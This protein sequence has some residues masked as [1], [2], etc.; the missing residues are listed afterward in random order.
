MRIIE[1]N[2]ELSTKELYG[3]TMSP[4]IGKMKEC[5]GQVLEIENWAKYADEDKNGVEKEI[6]S[7]QTKDG[8]VVATNSPTFIADFTRMTSLF[9]QTGETLDSIE[10]IEGKSK[11]GRTFITCCLA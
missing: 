2:K 9:K 3:M 1:T 6:L 8:D 4:K 10:I 5:V 7:I 11:A